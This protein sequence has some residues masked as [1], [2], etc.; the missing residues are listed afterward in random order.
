MIDFKTDLNLP[1]QITL[2]RLVCIPVYLM[3]LYI[4]VTWSN[5]VACIIFT[6]AASSDYFDGYLARKYNLVTDFGKIADP[7]ADKI[8][9]AASLV[10]LVEMGR[11]AGVIAI[12]LLGRDFY[13]GALR[14]LSSSKGIII[15][16]GKWGKIKTGTQM[17]A[18]G[19]VTFKESIFF[20]NMLTLGTILLYVS[21]I[22]SIYSAYIYT[23]EYQKNIAPKVNDV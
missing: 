20:L 10:A 13:M 9:V 1:N 22:F 3:I 18:L 12:I 5:I 7:I 16:A 14:D 2:F 11:I 15:A 6:V 17:V 21:I 23:V 8:L 4:D 19:M